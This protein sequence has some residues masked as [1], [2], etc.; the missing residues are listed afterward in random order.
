MTNEGMVVRT[1]YRMPI[2]VTVRVFMTG[3]SFSML[4][5]QQENEDYY[6]EPNIILMEA[7]RIEVFDEVES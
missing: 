1:L 6:G 2:L 7:A 5:I 4:W 3:C